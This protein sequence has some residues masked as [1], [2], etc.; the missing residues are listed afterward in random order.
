M[1]KIT[2]KIFAI[3]LEEVNGYSAEEAKRMAK[4]HEAHPAWERIERLLKNN[5]KLKK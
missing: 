2:E 4:E 3:I 5:V 1:K